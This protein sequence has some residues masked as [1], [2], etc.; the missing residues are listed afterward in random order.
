MLKMDAFR[1]RQLLLSMVGT[2]AIKGLALVVSF[3]TMPAYMRFFG[4]QVALG[5]W[6]TIV[7]AA[8]W[9]L[10]FD[11]G[12][13]NGLRNKL[14]EALVFKDA[15]RCSRL[16]SSA[17][18]ATALISLALLFGGI[19]LA[20]AFDWNAILGVDEGVIS[21]PILVRAIQILIIGLAAQLFLKTVSS[22]LYSLQKPATNNAIALVTS[23]LVL[24]W[25]LVAPV[26]SA[27]NNILTVALAYSVLSNIPLLVCTCVVFLGPLRRER[28]RLSCVSLRVVREIIGFGAAFLWAQ[29][30]FML[31]VGANEF[32]ISNLFGPLY[33]VEYQI[34]YKIFGLVASI[35]SLALTPLWSQIT[36]A[37]YEKDFEW[38]ARTYRMLHK[39]VLVAFAI[40]VVIAIFSQQ[41]IDIW[42]G[43]D[44]LF[45]EPFAAGV[46]IVYGTFYVWQSVE[47]TLA[48]GMGRL[49]VQNVVYTLTT[50][51]RIAVMVILS[52]FCENWVI[53]V[54]VNA[55]V[56]FLYC[57]VQ[58]ISTARTISF[59]KNRAR[60]HA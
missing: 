27:E 5:V 36:K 58:W 55:T 8:S 53:V 41:I 25:V 39:G 4:D 15:E 30:M 20:S 21:E 46:F 2:F 14:V 10:T 17:Y 52:N 12:I 6:L 13:G 49:R 48:C 43:A 18:F 38:V 45:V 24:I 37:Q 3:L 60:T 23:I 42:I 33:V 9:T 56:L 59:E 11:L 29:L 40:E 57:F 16:I 32:I 7:S 22:I 26:G 35:C 1:N 34:Y 31:L 19:F 47:S 28:P 51:I 50:P 44:Q 54:A